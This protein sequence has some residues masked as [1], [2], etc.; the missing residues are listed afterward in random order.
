AAGTVFPATVLRLPLAACSS[1]FSTGAAGL[2]GLRSRR[3]IRVEKGAG[4]GAA[5][6]PVV[7]GCDGTDRRSLLC[8][9]ASG[10]RSPCV[11]LVVVRSEG[12]RSLLNSW[13]ATVQGTSGG[14]GEGGLE[15]ALPLD[16]DSPDTLRRI[17]GA[18]TTFALDACVGEE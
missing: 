5:V 2:V 17:L 11:P 18:I 6:P 8:R 10:E 15:K 13:A 12:M 1:P 3:A 14:G 16:V 9:V 4:A 7:G